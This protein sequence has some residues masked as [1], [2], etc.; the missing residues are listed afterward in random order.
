MKNVLLLISL[1]FYAQVTYGF[2][3][4]DAECRNMGDYETIQVSHDGNSE[5]NFELYAELRNGGVESEVIP[6]GYKLVT[7]DIILSSSFYQ[8]LIRELGLDIHAISVMHDFTIASSP[9]H[10]DNKMIAIEGHYSRITTVM[11]VMGRTLRCQ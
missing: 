8:K 6:E 3:G 5:M 10:G 7:K 1:L 2:N 11:N 4:V 9:F